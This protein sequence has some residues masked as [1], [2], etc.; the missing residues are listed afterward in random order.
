M[1][2]FIFRLLGLSLLVLAFTVLAYDCM[3]MLANGEIMISTSKQLWLSLSERTF[4]PARS[5]LDTA[6][7]YLWTAVILPLLALPAPV[8]LGAAG[9]LLFLAGYRRKPPE[10]VSDF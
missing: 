7:P 4:E 10:I 6:V 9:S 3:R 2:N 5:R 8:L 1:I